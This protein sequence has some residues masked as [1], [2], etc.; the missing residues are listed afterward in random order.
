MG[1]K[2]EYSKLFNIY[3]VNPGITDYDYLWQNVILKVQSDQI[4]LASKNLYSFLEQNKISK[5][6]P[7]SLSCTELP[8]AAQHNMEMYHKYTFVDPNQALAEQ[9]INRAMQRTEKIEPELYKGWQNGIQQF[10][11]TCCANA[12]DKKC[13]LCCKGF[14]CAKASKDDET[15][16]LP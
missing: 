5:E 7:V 8:V 4:D 12:E 1:D 2:G 9:L 14:K 6:T 3:S 10:K 15:A 13:D 16:S 11:N